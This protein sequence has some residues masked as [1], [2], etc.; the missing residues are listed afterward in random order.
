MHVDSLTLMIPDALAKGVTGLLLFGAWL[1]F[2]SA[3]ALTVLG[4]RNCINAVAIAIISAGIASRRPEVIATGLAVTTIEI[5]RFLP[6]SRID[7]R[8]MIGRSR[9]TT[10]TWPMPTTFLPAMASRMTANAPWPI[11]SRGAM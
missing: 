10:T 4:R 8:E 1:H 6:R 11:G 3:H 9:L 5:E 7:A 2:R